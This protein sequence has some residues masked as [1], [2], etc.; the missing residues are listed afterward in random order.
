MKQ[1]IEMSKKKIG[2][3]EEIVKFIQLIYENEKIVVRIVINKPLTSNP[4]KKWL[5]PIFLSV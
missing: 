5:E 3:I 1:L 4:K 2:Q